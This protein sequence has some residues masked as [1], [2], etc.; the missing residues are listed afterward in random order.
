MTRIRGTLHED[1]R[2]F[3]II[4]RSV[5]LTMR[6]V[7]DKRCKETENTHF[8]LSNFFY[9]NC[10]VYDNVKKCRARQATHDSIIRRMC[11]ASWISKTIDTHSEY[12]I[13]IAFPRQQWLY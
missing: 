11:F 9:E 7:S 1:L 4:S 10:A 5:L 2:T 13:F 8:R 6:N 12:V 3:V